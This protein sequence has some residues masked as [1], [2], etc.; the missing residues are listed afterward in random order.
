MG[1]KAILCADENWAIGC[2]GSVLVSIPGDLRFFREK[3]EGHVVVM[4]RKTFDS[5]SRRPLPNRRNI[6]LTRSREL[7][8]P[9]VTF[10]YTEDELWDELRRYDPDEIYVIGGAVVYEMLLPFCD[11]VY[12]TRVAWHYQAD[13][14]FPDL[15]ASPEWELAYES[16]E[17]TCFD[18][19]YT[20]RTYRRC[21]GGAAGKKVS[22]ETAGTEERDL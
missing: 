14:W 21:A 8:C 3:T 16:E 5:I 7:R 17:Q 22:G 4:G 20:F 13:T 9:G 2:R 19:E 6:V 18:T 15:D 1:M 10:V 11:T 12:V